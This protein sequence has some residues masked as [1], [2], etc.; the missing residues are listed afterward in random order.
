MPE[1]PSF[2]KET[3]IKNIKKITVCG[4]KHDNRNMCKVWIIPQKRNCGQGEL[5]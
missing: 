2:I 4:G 1:E 3:T 5:L